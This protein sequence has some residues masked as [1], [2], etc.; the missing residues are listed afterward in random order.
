[1]N[2]NFDISR[3]LIP[4]KLKEGRLVRGLTASE[5]AAMVGVSRQALSQYET[6][7]T[8]PGGTVLSQILEV[9]NLPL[10]YFTSETFGGDFTDGESTYFR[11]LQTAE[12]SVREQQIIRIKWYFSIYK[13]LSQFLQ[14]PQINIP[15]YSEQGSFTQEKIE[16]IATQ[17]RTSWGLGL[18]PISNLLLLLEKNGVIIARAEFGDRKVD[19]CSTWMNDGRPFIFLGS[20]KISAV[21]SRFD[22]AHELGHLILH[23]N[24]PFEERQKKDVHVRIE[25]EAHCFAA[26]FLLPQESFSPEVMGFTIPFLTRLK[27][28]WKVSIAAMIYRC[29]DLHLVTEW[30]ALYLRKQMSAKRYHLREPLD[31]QIPIEIPSLLPKAINLLLKENIVTI[32][33]IL[34]KIPLY[35]REIEQLCNLS[36]NT[37]TLESNIVPLF[38]KK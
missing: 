26:A 11:S 32:P 29:L 28:R 13:H 17:V 18:G 4:N 23:R 31:D 33:E 19:A 22:A 16:W 38:L 24:I 2:A 10:A 27:E 37:L 7:K 9:L 34:D 30:Q 15:S 1:M 36:D 3:S 25:K 12:K 6:G 21:R 35:P 5:L 14:F 8:A 20:D